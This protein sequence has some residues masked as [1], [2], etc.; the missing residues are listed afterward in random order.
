[1]AVTKCPICQEFLVG[2]QWEKTS[3]GKN[4]LKNIEKG[5]WHDCPN[6]KFKKKT[7][8][9]KGQTKIYSVNDAPVLPE[10]YDSD[11]VGYY[12]TSGHYLGGYKDMPNKCPKCNK[13]TTVTEFRHTI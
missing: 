3:K 4:W 12:C 8:S 7:A 6:K 1:M 13:S 2:F 5:E 10:E 11:K 9:K